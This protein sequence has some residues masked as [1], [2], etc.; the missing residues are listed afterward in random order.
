MITLSTKQLVVQK[1]TV[2]YW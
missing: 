2:K 1:T